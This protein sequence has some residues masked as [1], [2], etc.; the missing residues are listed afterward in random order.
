M[1]ARAKCPQGK[2]SVR[3]KCPQAETSTRP[4]CPQAKTSVKVKCTG[5]KEYCT[6]SPCHAMSNV[7]VYTHIQDP[8][9]FYTRVFDAPFIAH[10]VTVKC[11]FMK[12]YVLESFDNCMIVCK[13]KNSSR[14]ILQNNCQSAYK[15]RKIMVR[16][17]V[18]FRMIPNLLI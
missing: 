15:E 7:P 4:K 18:L 1:S 17:I 13:T 5:K 3:A 12:T 11:V 6:L 2:I 16:I 10:K 8:T 14:A 9:R